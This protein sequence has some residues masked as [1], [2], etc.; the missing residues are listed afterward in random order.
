MPA[1]VTTQPYQ[2]SRM[3][4]LFPRKCPARAAPAD[5]ACRGT[6]CAVF[7][8]R[9]RSRGRVP[10]RSWEARAPT[11]RNT[12]QRINN[13]SPPSPPPSAGDSGCARAATRDGSSSV[14][15]PAQ[16]PSAPAATATRG[17]DTCMS[18]AQPAIAARNGLLRVQ[19]CVI[20]V[21]KCTSRSKVYFAFNGVLR[22]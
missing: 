3:R 9:L 4:Q 13:C 22:V 11:A 14:Q 1:D 17:T 8:P 2:D 7:A 18:R 15:P 6:A 19:G 20:R 5:F 10:G 12:K 16:P 21:R